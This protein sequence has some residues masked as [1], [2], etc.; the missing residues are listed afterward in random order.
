MQRKILY[1]VNPISGT[2]SKASIKEIIE[3][4]TKRAGF[5][6]A[7]YPSVAGG[8]YSFLFP[9]IKEEKFTDVVI[10]GGDGTINQAVNSL[11][12]LNVQFGII[13]CGS[14]NGLAFSAGIPKDPVKALQIVFR[15]NSRLTDAFY[16]NNQFACMLCGLGFDAQVAHDFANAPKRGLSTY[17]KKTVQN[18]FTSKAFPFVLTTGGKEIRTDAFFISVANSNQFG[19]HFTIAPKASLTDGL[20]DVVIMTRQNKFG[21]LFQTLKQISG[22]NKVQRV[23]IVDEKSSILYFQ[24]DHLQLTNKGGAPVHIDGDPVESIEEM[25]IRLEHDAFLLIQ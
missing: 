3:A 6:Y 16:I 19:N 11:R 8:D 7:V 22:F 21:V 24:T 15:G 25:N 23:D 2:R 5:R 18:F 10:A 17:V 1:I 4:E 13:P 20:L 12:K 9:I 14:G